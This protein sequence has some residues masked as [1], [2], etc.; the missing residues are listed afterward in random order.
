MRLRFGRYKAWDV[1]SVP[2]AYL[3]WLRHQPGT[4]TELREAITAT[5]SGK[6]TA[7]VH[8][9]RPFDARRAGCG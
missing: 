4:S 5:L 2:H 3:K 6:P 1:A 9:R 8:H 7:A